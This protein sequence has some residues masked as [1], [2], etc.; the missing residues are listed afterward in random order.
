[1]EVFKEFIG[2]SASEICEMVQ[3]EFTSSSTSSTIHTT[4]SDTDNE[5]DIDFT[6]ESENLDSN[7][8]NFLS[9]EVLGFENE[10][11]Q[12]QSSEAMNDDLDIDIVPQWSPDPDPQPNLIPENPPIPSLQTPDKPLNLVLVPL[13]D[14]KIR[15]IFNNFL[16]QREITS[17]LV[18]PSSKKK[19][20]TL[21]GKTM[22]ASEISAARLPSVLREHELKGVEFFD[23]IFAS[24]WLHND[25][26]ITGTKNNKLAAWNVYTEKFVTITL[27]QGQ[28]K[29]PTDNCGIHC[30]C[31][32]ESQ[33]L[34]ATGGFNPSEI[35]IF[36]LPSLLP[37]YT[38]EGHTDWLFGAAFID[39]NILVSGSRDCTCNIWRIDSDQSDCVD[40]NSIPSSIT[41]SIYPLKSTKAHSLKVR[42][43]KFNMQTKQ[44]ASL[45]ADGYIKFW[46]PGVFVPASEVKLNQNRELVCMAVDPV[47][48]LY[49]CGSQQY[50]SLV[51][52]RSNEVVREVESKDASSGVRS[53]SFNHHTLTVGGGLGRL[54]FYDLRTSGYINVDNNKDYLATGSGWL[55]K[56]RTYFDHFSDTPIPHSVYTHQYDPT[57]TKLFVAGGPLQL[58]LCGC[59]AAVWS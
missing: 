40:S 30:I 57:G 16:I 21:S 11:D 51:D 45:S 6:M 48:D 49:A 36:S 56:D 2:S 43:L 34:L 59:Y 37:L 4:S 47:R 9:C 38:L 42:D 19:N 54:S 27:P 41:T 53:V 50:V 5:F 55:R 22:L 10:S 33:T 23:K 39:D 1:M 3:P 28:S 31:V 52:P 12:H 44:F 26:V 13:R 7:Q 35:A 15:N 24:V 46:D 25:T 17:N 29:V 32:N 20:G 18:C 14:R 58:G 8:L